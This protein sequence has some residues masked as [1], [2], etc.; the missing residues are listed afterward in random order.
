MKKS[1]ITEFSDMRFES[2]S[3]LNGTNFDEAEGLEI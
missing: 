1:P 3:A 2:S